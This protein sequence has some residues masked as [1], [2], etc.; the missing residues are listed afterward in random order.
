MY[1]TK[2]LENLPSVPYE[3][4]QEAWNTINNTEIVDINP[5]GKR[6]EYRDRKLLRN[7]EEFPSTITI[8]RELSNSFSEWVKEHIV[9]S[10]TEI[11][12]SLTPA[13]RGHTMGAHTDYTNEF[14]LI[15]V[16]QE[17]GQNCRTVF[18][19]EKNQEFFRG[20]RQWLWVNDFDQLIE[21]DSIQMPR[22]KWC[23]TNTQFLHG[24]E[25][26]VEDRV[27]IHIGLLTD[28]NLKVK[29]D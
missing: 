9:E 22:G 2:I 27:A 14:R 25:N 16:L 6:S 28:Q 26:I 10:W 23:L 20:G 4:E 3:F 12:V 24:V 8:R 5:G 18:Y 15:Y 7:G 13:N 11:S 29:L 17:G 1:T 19:Q 21:R